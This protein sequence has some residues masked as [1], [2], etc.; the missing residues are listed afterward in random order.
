MGSSGAHTKTVKVISEY[1]CPIV[2]NKDN[3][4]GE[5]GHSDTFSVRQ[6][7]TDIVVTRTDST[8]GWGMNLEFQCCGSGKVSYI[9]YITKS[10]LKSFYTEVL[11]YPILSVSRYFNARL[12]GRRFM[13][14]LKQTMRRRSR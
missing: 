5:D 10:N 2:V 6:R 7:E 11:T 13:L 1:T 12:H 4:L 14:H 3:W 9:S 8:S